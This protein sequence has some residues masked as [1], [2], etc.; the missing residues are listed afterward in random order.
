LGFKIKKGG[1]F[2]FNPF[3]FGVFGG[4]QFLSFKKKI[5]GGP[6]FLWF[7]KGGQISKFKYLGFSG[8][9]P[10]NKGVV[11]FWV[12][13]EFQMGPK[14]SKTYLS[15][16][17]FPPIRFFRFFLG[18]SLKILDADCQKMILMNVPE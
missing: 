16:N 15:K 11:F 9:Q 10:Q 7:L 2:F 18:I 13:F 6:F 4:G 1:G 17:H 14:L 12:N 8:L 3:S 5:Q